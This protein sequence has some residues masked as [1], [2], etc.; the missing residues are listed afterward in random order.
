MY[1]GNIGAIKNDVKINNFVDG[2]RTADRSN[3]FINDSSK[4][5]DKKNDPLPK[6]PEPSFKKPAQNNSTSNINSSNI[7]SSNIDSSLNSNS[8]SS[9]VPK[10]SPND[11]SSVKIDT[12]KEESS[13][14]E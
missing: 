4:V 1:S 6:A 10:V 14:V 5:T 12:S 2:A 7:S 8:A 9:T 3:N 11:T 13:K